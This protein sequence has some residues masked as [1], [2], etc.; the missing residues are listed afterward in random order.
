MATPCAFGSTPVGRKDCLTGRPLATLG[1]SATTART[2]VVHPRILNMGVLLRWPAGHAGRKPTPRG[3][4]PA[5]SRRAAAALP[6]PGAHQ[7][8]AAALVLAVIGAQPGAVPAVVGALPRV[9]RVAV[10][11]APGPKVAAPALAAPA[12]ETVSAGNTAPEGAERLQ[13]LAC[14]AAFHASRGPRGPASASCGGRLHR[15]Y[16]YA[17]RAG[18]VPEAFV[19]L[20][21]RNCARAASRLWRIATGGGRRV[22]FCLTPALDGRPG[23]GARRRAG[24]KPGPREARAG[25]DDQDR[26][27]AE[28][29]GHPCPGADLAGG[30]AGLP[31]LGARAL[32]PLR[33]IPRPPRR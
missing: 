4:A 8:A 14:G 30:G 18:A 33:A 2:S 17:R 3:R 16:Y 9:V 24:I 11:R 25:S 13:A 27:T 20:P 1:A 12:V 7:P 22:A 23:F 19:L 28:C 15:F 32:P 6:A 5:S 29:A 10:R 26:R 31:G 21:P